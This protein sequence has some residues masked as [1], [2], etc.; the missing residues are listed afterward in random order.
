MLFKKTLSV[1]DFAAALAE[2]HGT[3]F[4]EEALTQ[5]IDAFGLVIEPKRMPVSKLGAEE[6]GKRTGL[7]CAEITTASPT[8]G[9]RLTASPLI[10]ARA[11]Y[12]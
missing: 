3:F 6:Q 2:A 11:V 9:L 4:S 1:Q 10:G 7:G 5:L 8:G 12:S